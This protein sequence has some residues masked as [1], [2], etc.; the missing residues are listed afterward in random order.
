MNRPGRPKKERP[1]QQMQLHTFCEE[2]DVPYTTAQMWIHSLDFPAYKIGGRWF[3][4]VPKYYK[5]RDQQHKKNY[6]YA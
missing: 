5:W 2:F 1:T 3:I 6:K 4:D